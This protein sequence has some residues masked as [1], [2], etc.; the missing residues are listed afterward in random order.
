MKVKLKSDLLVSNSGVAYQKQPTCTHSAAGSEFN[1]H[2]R[3]SHCSMKP[4]P[5]FSKLLR[6]ILGIFLILG[7]SLMIHGKT[8]TRHNLLYLLIHDLKMSRN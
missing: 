4:G 3:N 5:T 7:H 8:L 1:H 2:S 6:E